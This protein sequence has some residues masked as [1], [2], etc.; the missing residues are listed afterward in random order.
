[1]TS[2]K[3][4][5]DNNLS[6]V[7]VNADLAGNILLNTS[8]YKSRKTNWTIR[9]CIAVSLAVIMCFAFSATALA[10]TVPAVNDWLYSVNADVAE[11]LYPINLSAEDNGIKVNVLSATNNNDAV[12]V[13]FSV[14]D[15]T[16]NRVD[17]TTDIY[18]YSL[19]GPTAFTCELISYDEETKT[20]IF[21]M[22]GTGGSGLSGK[23]TTLSIDSFISNK[24]RYDWYDTGV[25]LKV[26]IDENASSAPIEDYKFTGGS[27]TGGMEV[28]ERMKVLTP[29]A[30][31]V[32]LGNGVDF[33]TI[34]NI[35]FVDG[36]LHIQTKWKQ[37]VDNHGSLSLGNSNGPA[38]S[39]NNYCFLTEND[40]RNGDASS[41]H[42]EY[43]FDVGSIEELK[44]S[45]LW[46]EFTEDGDYTQGVWKVNFRL[47]DILNK[48]LSLHW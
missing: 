38:D 3:S 21:R 33:V 16:G 10:A 17:A 26:L 2:L 48:K 15:T 28:G 47:S 13:Y 30:M 5:I 1:M 8:E 4:Y 18:N 24:T 43:V 36:Q 22:L 44:D 37:S 19:D 12:M 14:Q 20:A 39:G 7:K 23:M 46:A 9:K 45:R 29:D 11:M 41:E 25:D 32:S 34:S 31:D 35:G 42:I 6:S 27:Y 40:T